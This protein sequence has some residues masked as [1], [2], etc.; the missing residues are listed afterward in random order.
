[1]TLASVLKL[2]A[3]TLLLAGGDAE[4]LDQVRPVLECF[5]ETIHYLGPLGSGHKAKVIH[6][7]I[8][9]GNA[10]ILAEAFCTAAKNELSTADMPVV[11][12]D[13]VLSMAL[14]WLE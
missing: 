7:F 8:S 12:S 6:N 11:L 9:Q 14:A 3:A 4:V 5:S 13:R 10:T 2:C 1:M